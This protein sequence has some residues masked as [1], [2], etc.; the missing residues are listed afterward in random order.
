MDW[1]TVHLQW[2]SDHIGIRPGLLA[3]LLYSI[4]II[5]VLLLAN[6]LIRRFINRHIAEPS[7]Q[8][9]ARKTFSYA[10]GFLSVVLI[11]WIWFGSM[12]GIATYL[13]ILSAGLAVALQDPLTN[14]AGWLFI[15][16]RRPFEVGDRIE[17]N[18]IAGDVVD[19]RLFQ[20]SIIEIGNWVD[21]DQSTG[22]IIH[23]PNGYVF[24]HAAANYN[25]GF[26]FIWNELPIQ[27]TFESNWR[28]AKEILLKIAQ[29][30][31]PFDSEKAAEQVR[32]STRK[33]L[34]HYTHLTPIVWTSVADSGVVLTIRYL[35]DPRR[36]RS[37]AANIWESVLDAFSHA[38]DID[39]AYPTQRVYLNPAEGKPE[40]G[41]K[42]KAIGVKITENKPS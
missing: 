5:V 22:R 40:T 6:A 41:G 9:G 35:C 16:F 11:V 21:A 7:R 38:D 8:Y 30:N 24:K 36:R 23:I 3:N 26:N 20:F 10:L 27:V 15:M 14:L 19:V 12:G 31:N 32:R 29:Q 39:L 17:I 37:T 2:V 34:V 28:K 13:G 42:D 25:Q 1:L 4:L 33:F 18:G